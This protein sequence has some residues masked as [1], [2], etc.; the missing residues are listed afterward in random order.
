MG[1]VEQLDLVGLLLLLNNTD[2]IS[3]VKSPVEESAG[4][5]GVVATVW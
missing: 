2:F 4:D 3:K 5:F 1:V